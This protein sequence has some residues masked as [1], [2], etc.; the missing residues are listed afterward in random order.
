MIQDRPRTFSSP[1][2]TV[3]RL[4]DRERDIALLVADG[5]KDVVIAR[6]L[7]LSHATIKNYVRRV[8]IRL[9]LADRAGIIAWVTARRDPNQPE[10][11]LVRADPTRRWEPSGRVTNRSRGAR[12]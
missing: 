5:L 2:P 8:R 6:R 11:G 9:H 7:G 12:V 4:S 1:D 3:R 10:G